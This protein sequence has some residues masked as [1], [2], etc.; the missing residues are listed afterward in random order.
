MKEVAVFIM[1]CKHI[2]ME[3]VCEFLDPFLNYSVMRVPISSSC[4]RY[5]RNLVST[6]MAFCCS[7]PEDA[8][9][10]IKLLAG[11]LKYIPCKNA[12][13]SLYSS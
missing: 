11:R 5:L 9:P 10:I 6:M 7:S 13:V 3:A 1:K 12:E 8:I 4:S 2:G